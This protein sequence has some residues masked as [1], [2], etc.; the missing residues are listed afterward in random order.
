MKG[1]LKGSRWLRELTA[2]GISAVLLLAELIGEPRFLRIAGRHPLVWRHIYIAVLLCAVFAAAAF[3]LRAVTIGGAIAGFAVALI[4]YLELGS[5]G[6]AMLVFAFILTWAATLAGRKRKRALGLAESSSGRDGFQVLANIGL[7]G[8]LAI[9]G[10]GVGALAVIAEAVADTVSSEIG[11]A[12]GGPPRLITTRESVPI[13]TNGAVTLIGTCAGA[14]A[15]F[16]VAMVVI[17]EWRHEVAANLL[18]GDLLTLAML[19]A[20]PAILGMLFDSWLGAWAEGRYLT[21]D[22]VNFIS[23]A[24]AAAVSI[25]LTS[26]FIVE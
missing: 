21:N 19:V 17:D 14:I 10:R 9:A 6:F 5:R 22:T 26:I 16:V 20:V 8:L 18:I 12:F 3:A 24:A 23:T 2:I 25:A 7:A 15:S 13:G 4:L 11:Q 1:S